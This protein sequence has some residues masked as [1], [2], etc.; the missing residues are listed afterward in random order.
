M[1]AEILPI[2]ALTVIF[3]SCLI[4]SYSRSVCKNSRKRCGKQCCEF[5]VSFDGGKCMRLMITSLLTGCAGV[6]WA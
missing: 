6:S 2:V 3:L 4:V 5:K 1:F